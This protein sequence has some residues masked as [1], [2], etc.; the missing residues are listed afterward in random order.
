M[1]N[2]T[3]IDLDSGEVDRR[4]QYLRRPRVQRKSHRQIFE[5]ET[6]RLCVNKRNELT[7]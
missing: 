6:I 5:E 1:L 4:R 2:G 7:W 3:V